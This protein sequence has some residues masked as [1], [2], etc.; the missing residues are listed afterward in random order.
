MAKVF[1]TKELGTTICSRQKIKTEIDIL[2]QIKE[3]KMG[4]YR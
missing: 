3:K 1:K 4:T 2:V